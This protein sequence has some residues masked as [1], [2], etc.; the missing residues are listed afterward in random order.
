MH[1]IVRAV[2]KMPD[3]DP[4]CAVDPSGA[5]GRAWMDEAFEHAPDMA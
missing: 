2:Y 5:P 1:R 4:K 3:N